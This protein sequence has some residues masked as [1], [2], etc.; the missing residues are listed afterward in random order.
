MK[1]IVQAK[2]LKV[3]RALREFIERH[4]QKLDKL[5]QKVTSVRVYL[6]LST[7]KSSKSKNVLVKYKIEVPGQDLWVE[8]A[9][10]DFY[11][12]IVDAVDAATRK[13]RKNKEKQLEY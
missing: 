8:V 2:S 10:Y 5:G 6:E 9:G 7:K 11:D 4:S 13:L 1:V 3:T 12:A